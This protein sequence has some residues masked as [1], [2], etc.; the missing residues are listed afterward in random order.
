MLKTIALALL[1]A[2]VAHADAPKPPSSEEALVANV[3]DAKWT[4]PKLPELP[5]G[6]LAAPIAVDPASGAP[7]GYAKLPGGYT[8]PLHWHAFNEYSVLI[9]GK[10]S[11]TVDGKAHALLPGG[12]IVIPAKAHHKV[13]CEAGTEC[14]IL[15]RRGGPADYHFDKE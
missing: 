3:A 15:T 9:A 2:G 5:P 14:L 1:F 7:I 12:Y 10:A 6:L 8:L 11:V 4:A 13:L